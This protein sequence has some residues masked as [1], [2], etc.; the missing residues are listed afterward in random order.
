[1]ERRPKQYETNW[2]VYM[3]ENRVNGKKYIGITSQKP[4]KRWQN[5]A[6]YAQQPRFFNAIKKYGWDAFRHEIL[7][8]DLTQSEA[9]RLE[10]ELIAKYETMNP[11]KGYN[12]TAGGSATKGW[13]PTAE[14]RQRI[15][16]SLKGL[17]AGEKNPFYGKHHSEETRQKLRDLTRARNMTGEKNPNYGKKADAETLAKMSAN[18]KGKLTGAE[19]PAARPVLCVETGQTFS[20]SKDAAAFIGRAPARICESCRHPNRT[21]GG[22]H[23]RYAE[24]VGSNG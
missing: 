4:T 17:S 19:N 1:M 24:A 8:T 6:G 20:T 14:T 7:Y 13:V 9:E 2:C 15:S 22:Y 18:R 23:W 10:V 5:G 11:S 16:D 12:S 21:A 3:H